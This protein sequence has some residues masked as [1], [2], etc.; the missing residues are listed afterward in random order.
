MSVSDS[1]GP[2]EGKESLPEHKK[3]VSVRAAN[4]HSCEDLLVETLWRESP[5]GFLPVF[6]LQ[7][8]QAVTEL[9]EVRHGTTLVVLR[10]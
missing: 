6:P 8:T 3:T 7:P 9:R 4:A 1:V 10:C 5:T 2:G